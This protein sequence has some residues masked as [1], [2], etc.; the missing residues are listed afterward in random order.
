M[1]ASRIGLALAGVLLTAGRSGAAPAEIPGP[2]L[3]IA[4]AGASVPEALAAKDRSHPIDVR[5]GADWSAIET[6]QGAYDWSSIAS[7]IKTLSARGARVTLCVRGESPFHPRGAGEGALPD[8]AWL[9]AWTSLL[10]SA[11]ASFGDALAVVEIG[12]HPETTFDAVAYAFVLKSSSLA[13]K[14]EAKAHGFDVRVAQGAV[15]SDAL[16]WQKTLWDNDAAPYADV[17]PVAFAPGADV[18]S[19]V[20]AFAGEAA[21]HPPAAELRAHVAASPADGWSSFRGAVSALA[22]QAATA[23]VA[24]PAE[25]DAGERVTRVVMELQARLAADY[26]P[27]PRGGLALRTQ[28]GGRNEGDVI[29]GRFLHAK[30][31]ATIVV[32]QAP[33][34]GEPEAQGRLLLDTVDVK[35]PEVLDLASGAA[36]KTGPAAVPGEK[37]RALRVLLSDHPLAVV[38]DRAAV[39]EP[40]LDAPAEDVNV[41]TTRGLTAEEIIAKNRQVQKIQDD[42]LSRW[43]AKGRADIHFKLAQGG[44]SIDVGIESTYFWRRGTPLTWQQTR[45]FINGNVVT[46]KKI[47][48]LPLIQPEKVLTLPLDLTFDKTYEYKLDGEDTVDHRPAYIV[49]FTPAAEL[50]GKSL[51]RGR[52]WIDKESFVRLRTSVIQTNLEAPVLQNE[53]TD[54]YVPVTGGD[55]AT[56]ILIGRIDG[57]QLWSGW[58]RNFVVRRELAFSHFEIN[59]SEAQFQNALN[60]A[61]ASDD[62]MLEDTDRGFRYLKKQPGGERVVE[63]KVKTDALAGLA[64][65]FKDDS[66]GGALPLIGVNWFDTDFLKKKIQ[67][68]AFFAVVFAYVNLTDP[69]VRGTKVDLGLEASLFAWKLD[70]KFFVDGAEDVTQRVQ[71]RSQYLTG[72]VGYPLGE[73]FK[74]AAMGDIAWNAYFD[75]S[76]ARDALVAQNA[77]NGTSLTFVL[78]SDHQV[79]S[80]TLQ[81]EFN[82]MGYSITA[83]GSASWRSKWTPWGLYDA[84]NGFVDPTFNPAQKSFQTWKLTLFKE[85]YLPKFQKLKAELDYLDG[86][87]LD[88]FSQYGFG[89][90]GGASLVGFGGTG[91]RFDTGYLASTGWGFNI[92]NAVSFNASAEFAHVKDNLEDDRFRDHTGVGLSFNVVGPWKTVWQGSY[93]RAIAS[94]VPGLVGKQEFQLVVFKLF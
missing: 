18:A 7:A 19:G 27:A 93:G 66:T 87:N 68:N 78:P 79:Y 72:R 91:V 2:S 48:E 49:A 21:L 34:T 13:V 46:W 89:R 61:S 8:G 33:L 71:R 92:L 81:L 58:G 83:A 75:S 65:A 20:A 84:V 12:E 31:F 36:F 10:R 45:Y 90:F 26:A 59:G 80:G 53:E 70:D 22:S 9:E 14:A 55:G 52:V 62:Q 47:P 50:A 37:A 15:G 60:A 16:A 44:G 24:L 63:E 67:F 74:F 57:Q 43:I 69:S 17:L 88:R 86:S 77:A 94:D 73:F 3:G 25:P 39:N 54:T 85:W 30:D 35:D 82:R 64:G 51:Y 1:L 29:V 23:L 11:V 28:E 56:Y 4:L 32:Y 6:A 38:W 5:V 42:R 41:A 76:D 40:G